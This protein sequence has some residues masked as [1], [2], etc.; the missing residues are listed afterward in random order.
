MKEDSGI[1]TGIIA[2]GHGAID[3]AAAAGWSLSVLRSAAGG[4]DHPFVFLAAVG[5]EPVAGQCRFAWTDAGSPAR[6]VV[7]RGGAS[8]DTMQ[9]VGTVYHRG[10]SACC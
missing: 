8:C 4:R 1:R 3:E 10:K 5:F 6:F 2:G 9:E 7:C